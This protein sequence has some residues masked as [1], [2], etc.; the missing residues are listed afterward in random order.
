LFTWWLSRGRRAIGCRRLRAEARADKIV[1]APQSGFLGCFTLLLRA[2][3]APGTNNLQLQRFLS[4]EPAHGTDMQDRV[5]MLGLHICT[6][7][8]AD[9]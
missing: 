6:L 2:L 5:H 9:L 1:P 3:S 8:A 4:R 7:D